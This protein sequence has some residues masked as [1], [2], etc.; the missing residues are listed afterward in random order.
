MPSEI[1]WF[2]NDLRANPFEHTWLV[3]QVPAWL[4]YDF[5]AGRAKIIQRYRINSNLEGYH[6]ELSKNSHGRVFKR[7]FD[8]SNTACPRAALDS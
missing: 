8:D 2:D 1:P 4:Q 7:L 3:S 5:R 6:P